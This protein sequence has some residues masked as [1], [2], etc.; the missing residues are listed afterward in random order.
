MQ[1]IYDRAML[2][3]DG[4]WKQVALYDNEI[5]CLKTFLS[6]HV[7]Q[8]QQLGRAEFIAAIDAASKDIIAQG[9]KL[10]TEAETQ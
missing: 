1:D 3:G 2:L 5:D 9:H 7:F 10:T 4:C 8:V 6:L